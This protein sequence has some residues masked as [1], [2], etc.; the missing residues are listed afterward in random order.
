MGE[1]KQKVAKSFFWVAIDGVG[2]SLLQFVIGIILARIL[3]PEEFGTVGV[4]A[5][6]IALSMV[7]VNSGF[8][9]ALIR[10]KHVSEADY[11]TV[12]WFNIFVSVLFFAILWFTSPLIADFYNE[13][14]LSD[15]VKVVSVNLLINAASSIQNV[16]L[17]RNFKFRQLTV[18][19]IISKIISGSLAIYMAFSGFGLWSLV[20][21]ELIGNI[22]RMILLWV[23]GK[24]L[25]KFIFSKNSFRELF[26]FSSKLLYSG[27]SST[28][29]RNIYPVLIGKFFSLSEV[30]YFNR[31]EGLKNMSIH[32]LTGM[33]QKVTLPMFSEIQD[34]QEAFKRN[35]TK[36]IQLTVLLSGY[37]LVLLFVTGEPLTEFVYTAKWLPMVPMLKIL[38]IGGIFYPLNA[39]NYNMIGVK[40]RSD[41]V[42]NLSF[43]N[44]ALTLVS[45]GVG[46]IWGLMGLVVAYSIKSVI[47]Y[48]L[49]VYF[50]NKVINY[51]FMEQFNDIKRI[52]LVIIFT[53][54]IG[55]IVMPVFHG[56]V[57]KLIAAFFICSLTYV[58]TTLLFRIDVSKEAH[59]ILKELFRKGLK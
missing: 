38:V 7:F 41:I 6:F 25:P 22:T 40:G 15:V 18:I 5:I 42:M 3:L 11:H 12:F 46:I 50:T 32:L 21:K 19:G 9:F 8:G 14:I 54:G 58:I 55:S 13:A 52:G 47:S 36:V 44:Q 39:L 34:D 43:S 23:G 45:I 53:A 1:F 28:V 59:S 49:V 37:P 27:V 4:I 29:L 33:I 51:P 31:A 48:L 57:L 2:Q 56:T 26:S 20:Y 10:K 16:K 17:T 30:G 24:F 35:Y